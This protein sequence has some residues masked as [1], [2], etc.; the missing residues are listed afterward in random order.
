MFRALLF[1]S[2]C[3]ALSLLSG[4]AGSTSKPVVWQD[5][6][7][8]D[9]V[10]PEPPDQPR[11]RYL[12]SLY[13]PGDFKEKSRTS[14][15]LDWLL[16]EQ[17]EDFPLLSP[18]AVAVSRSGPV[19]VADNGARMLYRLDLNRRK[20]DYFQEF[21]GF[22]LVSP[23][24]VVVDD[25]RQRVFL[26]DAAYRQIFVLDSDGK[27]L[28]S[29]GPEGGFERPAGMAL[30][31]AGRLLVADAMAGVV[32]IFNPDGT[33]AS[34]I[35]S[36]VSPDGRFRRPLNVAVGP[37]GEI[38]I[39]DA[40]AFHVEVQSAQG[41]LLGTIGQLG[42]AAGYMARPKGLAVDQ[43]GHVF[44]SDSAFDNIQVFDMA[45]NLLMFWGGAGRQPGQFSLPAGL[46]IDHE[47]RFFVADSYNHRVQVFQ[48]LP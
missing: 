29:W 15:V 21:A 35:Q 41:E 48:L 9:F 47:G 17:Q 25:E 10:W 27:Y 43:D 33:M 4:C 7:A 3:L 12:R 2:L 22:Q 1:F 5:E 18:F 38:L 14:V 46:F 6:A 45:G 40:F 23:S 8:V 39:L 13:G 31:S 44:V 26:A 28:D 36:R 24:G 11:V 16:G 37:G 32:Y 19:W 30:D 20:V 42:D 34:Q